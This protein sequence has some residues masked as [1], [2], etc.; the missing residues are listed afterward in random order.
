MIRRFLLPFMPLYAAVIA[1]KNTAYNRGRLKTQHLKWPVISVG[2]IS[3][4]G[5]GKTPLV[6]CLARLLV[7]QGIHVDI[8]SR[9]YGRNSYAVE[10]VDPAGTAER[11][12]DEP[13]L[14]AQ[15]VD[16]PV[17]V[18]ASR[19]A[20]GFLAEKDRK[21]PRI[22]LLD[23][24]FQHRS[25]VRDL[26]IVVVHRRDFSEG[27]LPSGNLRE[28][29]SA[30]RRASVV[31]LR[32]ED[33]DLEARL[34]KHGIAAPIWWVRRSMN[35]PLSIG[36]AVAFCGIA[37]PDEFFRS[38]GM[39]VE[40]AIE[41]AFPDHH[42]Y[43]DADIEQLAWTAHS[44]IARAFLTTEKDFVRLSES[45]RQRLTAVAPLDVAKLEVCLLDEDAA[46]RQ[47]HQH[48][49]TISSHPV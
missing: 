13:L 25:L 29:L 44:A 32:D 12:G 24:G 33:R 34:R 9:G 8:L 20:A 35:V 14:M 41:K 22:H 6:I 1:A 5:S 4:G 31:V 45:Q 19:F 16:V 18:G 37:R 3:T 27:L 10:R 46:L 2:N 43:T 17:Y 11:Y 40:V 38:V 26:D 23:D 42:Q 39:N 30:L 28:P 36:G 15:S 48:L 21:G 7:R 47:L 49:E